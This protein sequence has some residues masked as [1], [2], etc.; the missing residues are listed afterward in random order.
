VLD[1]AGGRTLSTIRT[2]RG[3]P[4]LLSPYP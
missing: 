1:L 2:G 4:H 3:S